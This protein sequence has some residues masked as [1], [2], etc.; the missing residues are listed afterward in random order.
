MRTAPILGLAAL[1]AASACVQRTTETDFGELQ[2]LRW[3]GTLSRPAAAD[4]MTVPP[5]IAGSATLAP[6]TN[7]TQSTATVMVAN[8]EPGAKHPWHIHAGTCG[9]GGGI[10]GPPDS[11]TP[12]TI[13]TN[14]RGEISVTLPFS[15]PTQG[16]FY[17]NVH[18]SATDLKTI[19]A[20]GPLTLPG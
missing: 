14:G 6:A 11:Y 12:I 20:C 17:V 13:G 15:T 7:P 19:V 5:R 4:S 8:A 16:Q 18:K 9:S 3:S 10:V 1:L 2:M